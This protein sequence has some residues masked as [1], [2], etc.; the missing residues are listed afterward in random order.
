MTTQY[1]FVVESEDRNGNRTDQG[2]WTYNE[3]GSEKYAHITSMEAAVNTARAEVCAWWDDVTAEPD[4]SPGDK[5]DLIIITVTG[6]DDETEDD[7][8]EREI[9]M[10]LNVH[11][12]WV[13]E[14]NYP[15]YY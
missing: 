11:D 13:D 4:D 10:R 5:H 7:E 6:R 8:D 14:R 9:R 1:L 15:I 3:I 2:L 12:E